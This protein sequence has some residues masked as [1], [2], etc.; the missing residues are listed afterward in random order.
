MPSKR[1]LLAA[2]STVACLALLGVVAVG[3]TTQSQAGKATAAAPIVKTHVKTVKRTVHVKNKRTIKVVRSSPAGSAGVVAIAA[4]AEQV[5]TAPS[6]ASQA[7]ARSSAPSYSEAER[8]SGSGSGS[9][10]DIR[11]Q[12]SELSHETENQGVETDD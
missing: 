4:S 10:A 9:E 8:G 5:G 7:V 3:S 1:A 2:T 11:D 6:Q 12:E